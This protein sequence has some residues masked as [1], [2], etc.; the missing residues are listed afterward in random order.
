MS[1]RSHSRLRQR[2]LLY[3]PSRP[4]VRRSTLAAGSYFGEY[5][6]LTGKK[7]TASVVALTLCELYCLTRRDYLRCLKNWPQ[8]M[9][10][11]KVRR[12]GD[13]AMQLDELMPGCVWGG[14]R[15]GGG[16]RGEWRGAAQA[17]GAEHRSVR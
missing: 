9:E 14:G 3:D 12:K 11:I 8:V 15:A 17:A 7:R 13:A 5:A 10:T 1:E 2:I 16:M 4:Y 6:C